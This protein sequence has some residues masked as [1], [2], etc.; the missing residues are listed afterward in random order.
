[1]SGRN[2]HGLGRNIPK[3]IKQKIRQDAGFGCVI[4]GLAICTYEHIEPE[5]HSAKKHDPSRMTYLCH[6]C[7]G[8]HTRKQLSKETIWAAKS[9]PKALTVGYSFEKFDIGTSSPTIT[10]GPLRISN[11]ASVITINGKSILSIAA[12]LAPGRPFLLSAVF[13]DYGSRVL[14]SSA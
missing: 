13:T 1:M 5:F 6:Q 7:A 3:S 12:P 11:C 10:L 8:K 9:N 2:K 4:C 14:L